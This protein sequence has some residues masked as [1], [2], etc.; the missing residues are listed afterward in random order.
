MGVVTGNVLCWVQFQA[1]TCF[2]FSNCR[3]G[4]ALPEICLLHTYLVLIFKKVCEGGAGEGMSKLLLM[5][6][7]V[8]A[9]RGQ[10]WPIL[11]LELQV[12]VTSPI[13]GILGA[14]H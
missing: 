11:K 13:V 7:P 8:E 1:P 5:S 3:P 14:K 6:V 12:V 10:Q 9:R 2:G 4:K